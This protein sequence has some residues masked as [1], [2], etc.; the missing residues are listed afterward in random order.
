MNGSVFLRE[1]NQ[2]GKK[3]ETEMKKKITNKTLAVITALAML[4]A[5][6]CAVLLK[7]VL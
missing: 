5:M 3:G 1:N 7:T 2:N 4:F 6:G